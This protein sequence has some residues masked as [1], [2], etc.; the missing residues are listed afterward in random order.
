[1]LS[2]VAGKNIED[3]TVKELLAIASEASIQSYGPQTR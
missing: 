1:M 3:L 2:N